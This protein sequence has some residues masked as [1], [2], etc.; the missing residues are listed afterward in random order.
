MV[1]SRRRAEVIDD[2]RDYNA[3]N[4]DEEIEVG[5]PR[6]ISHVNWNHERFQQGENDNE[7]NAGE[8]V[9]NQFSHAIKIVQIKNNSCKKSEKR[10][11]NSPTSS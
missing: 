5:E 11:R 9:R 2:A 6:F 7:E 3:H 4:P 10:R 1:N 8:H